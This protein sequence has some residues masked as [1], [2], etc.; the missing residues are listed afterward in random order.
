LPHSFVE[1]LGEEY[2][3]ARADLRAKRS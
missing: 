2:A 1:A 3:R